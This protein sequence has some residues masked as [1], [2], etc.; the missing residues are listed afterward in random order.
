MS[1]ELAWSSMDIETK[2]TAWEIELL[3][4]VQALGSAPSITG[5]GRKARAGGT[6]S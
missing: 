1:V 2:G 6:G 4:R 3:G 5:N